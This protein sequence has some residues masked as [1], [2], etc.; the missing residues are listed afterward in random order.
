M[1][2]RGKPPQ[3][4]TVNRA[5]RCVKR[6]KQ[7]SCVHVAEASSVVGHLNAQDSGSLRS[8]CTTMVTV[9]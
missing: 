4:L 3:A 2:Q 6:P 7:R 9:Q 5:A 8:L 1:K